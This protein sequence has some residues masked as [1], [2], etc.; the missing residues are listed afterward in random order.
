M[1]PVSTPS[2]L[3]AAPLIVL[4]LGIAAVGVQALMLSPL[5]T[6]MARAL[7]VG[8][9]ELGIAS[10]AYG[11]GVAIAA[12]AAAP[13][14][15]QGSK[16]LLLRVA[17]GVMAAGLMLCA[18]AWTWVL[19]GL[20]QFIAGLAAGVIIPG[21][22]ALAA[23]I[24]PATMRARAAGRVIF[25][26]SVALVAGVPLAALLAD[27]MGW[28]GTFAF[29]AGLALLMVAAAGLLPFAESEAHRRSAY[30]GA[31]A[32]KGVPLLLSATF[33]YMIGFYQTYAFIGDHVRSLHG[34]GAWLGGAIACAYGAGFGVAVVLDGWIDR[35]GPRRL[36]AFALFLVGLNYIALPFA[37]ASL[38]AT[39]LYPF[40]WGVANHLCMTVLVSLMS[41]TP[42]EVR[43]TA[44]GLFSAV[45]YLAQ[46]LGS[47]VYGGIYAAHGFMAVSLAAAATLF[48]AAAAAALA[49]WLKGPL[50]APRN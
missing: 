31:L 27:A 35:T 9:R 47:A 33:A 12:F 21:S 50:N 24:T 22:Y 14:L 25:G 13:R 1:I 17:F 16:R 40:A 46:G 18:A 39:V 43:G 4:I 49:P 28:R 42:P 11:A 3:P 26:W 38:L 45:T 30:G 5:L 6:D 32:A 15:A 29:V 10:G 8:P 2:R 23:E 20:G 34:T 36:L 7:G 37:T 41:A 44:M 19:L 48:A